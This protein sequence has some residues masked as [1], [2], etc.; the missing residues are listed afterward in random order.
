[1]SKQRILIVDDEK[2]I[3]ELLRYNLESNG[4]IIDEANSGEEAVEKIK[5]KQYDLIILDIMLPGIDGLEVLRKIRQDIGMKSL[6][7]ILLTAK[8]SEIDKVVGLELGADDYIVKPFG[9]Y[10]LVARVKS[11][12]RRLEIYRSEVEE[13][14]SVHFNDLIIDRD[15]YAVTKSGEQ[16]TLTH[17]E[18][19]L[20]YLLAKN[21]GRVFDREFLLESIW[22]YEYLGESRTVDVHI[23]NLRKKL[24]D[25]DK[26]PGYIVTIRGVGYKFIDEGGKE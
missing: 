16:V 26:T 19:E 9:V 15:K 14:S 7:V 2:H 23:R 20:L 3:L 24:G 12:F 17:K 13:S 1:M 8:G 21:P 11:V 5:E 18:F 10:E 25:V 4:Y 6:P 22:G